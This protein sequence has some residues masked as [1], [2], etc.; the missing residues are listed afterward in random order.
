MFIFA[1]IVRRV[2]LVVQNGVLQE[3]WG[4]DGVHG[5]SECGMNTWDTALW[6]Y[7]QATSAE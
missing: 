4:D 7:S 2:V 5:A 3:H 1:A 6:A